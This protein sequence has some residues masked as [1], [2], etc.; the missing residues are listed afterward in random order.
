M[1]MAYL[2]LLPALPFLTVTT[3][4]GFYCKSSAR[5]HH[6]K[7]AILLAEGALKA[8]G[9]KTDKI[10]AAGYSL[11]AMT[12]AN[13][14]GVF[15][16]DTRLRGVVHFSGTYDA[17]K[18]IDFEYSSLTWQCYLAANCKMSML[19]KRLCKIAVKR[20]VDLKRVMSRQVTNINDFE[21]EWVA[22][23]F[24]YDGVLGPNGYYTATFL[25]SEERWKKVEIPVLAI[26]SRDD[27][28]THAD[29]L[30][31]EEYSAG[32]PNLLFLITDVGGHVGWPWGFKPW[33]RGFDFMNESIATFVEAV[34]TL[35]NK[36]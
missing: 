2:G 31:A 7:K 9:H 26:A 22:P 6:L 27:P 14:C 24:G 30:R 32:N 18:N 33:E 8:T 13:Y 4:A 34:L 1:V 15:G 10:F 20:G 21:R 3:K 11:G 23:L 35:G 29:A 28:I 12:L 17:S 19:K 36:S 25:A 16:S 5:N